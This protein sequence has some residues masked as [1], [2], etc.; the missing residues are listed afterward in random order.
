[1]KTKLLAAVGVLSVVMAT[2]VAFAD[3]TTATTAPG[4][5]GAA[6]TTPDTSAISSSTGAASDA[7]SAT[8]QASQ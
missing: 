5:S 8:S 3:D 1:M 7:M 6:T 2:S 4:M